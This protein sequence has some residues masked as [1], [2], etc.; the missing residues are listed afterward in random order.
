MG[1]VYDLP[2]GA[3]DTVF[4]YLGDKPK[5]K[6]L[7]REDLSECIVSE[8]SIHKDSPEPLFTALCYAEAEYGR[9]W[10]S[11]FGKLIF[12]LDQYFALRG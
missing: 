1:K 8:I 9:F 6:K 2:C 5:R 11:D 4:A 3:G 10:Q 7:H 12:T